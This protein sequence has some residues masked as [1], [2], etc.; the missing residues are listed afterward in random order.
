MS[1]RLKHFSFVSRVRLQADRDD[2]PGYKAGPYV[3][4]HVKSALKRQ[5][6]GGL[7]WTRINEP[8]QRLEHPSCWAFPGKTADSSFGIIR[9]GKRGP[10]ICR[11]RGVRSAADADRPLDHGAAAAT[12]TREVTCDDLSTSYAFESQRFSPSSSHSAVTR[13]PK[14]RPVT[15]AA[16]SPMRKA[17]PSLWPSWKRSGSRPDQ[18]STALAARV[19]RTTSTCPPAPT[20]SR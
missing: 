19:S 11:K 17:A 13:C 3:C 1:G 6:G 16:R 4:V 10:E 15:S 18:R 5:T 12:R 8:V 7:A 9:M 2:G 20:T 14:A